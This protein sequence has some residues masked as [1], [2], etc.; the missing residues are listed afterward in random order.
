MFKHTMVVKTLTITEDAYNS[1]KQLKH[2]GESFSEVIKRVSGQ[3]MRIKDLW[4]TLVETPNE[5][6]A[7]AGRVKEARKELGKGF[8]ER[9]KRVHFR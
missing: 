2:E 5:M 1:L 3:K 6:E 4:G 9:M 8:D 7:F